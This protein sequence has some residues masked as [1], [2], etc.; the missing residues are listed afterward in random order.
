MILLTGRAGTDDRLDGLS[1]GDDYLT[2]PFPVSE[3]RLRVKN[4]LDNQQKWQER[5]RLQPFNPGAPLS[6][7]DEAFLQRA[8]AVVEQHYANPDFRS[9]TF[10]DEMAM[11]KMQL[12][13]KLKALTGQT[14]NEFVRIYRLRQAANRRN[15]V[16]DTVADVAYASGF[17]NLSYF[18]KCFGEQ[19]GVLPSAYASRKN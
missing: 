9:K 6:P 7:P 14:P 11:G 16:N 5:V 8:Y 17:N 18:S 15:G 12:Y 3:P 4:L 10:E 1:T 19:Y 2:K 13:R